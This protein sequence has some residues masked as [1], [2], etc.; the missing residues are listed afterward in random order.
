MTH[1][2]QHRERSVGIRELKC[3]HRKSF[4][5]ILPERRLLDVDGL[6]STDINT[7]LE[8]LLL[9]AEEVEDVGIGVG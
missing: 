3:I 9:T 2:Y 4:W 8:C 7:L 5:H 6:A 1:G